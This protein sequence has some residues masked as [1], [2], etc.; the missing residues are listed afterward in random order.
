MVI[1]VCHSEK[2]YAFRVKRVL[3]RGRP[4]VCDARKE[5]VPFLMLLRGNSAAAGEGLV[6]QFKSGHAAHGEFTPIGEAPAAAFAADLIREEVHHAF[7]NSVILW[8]GDT[9]FALVRKAQQPRLVNR[10]QDEFMSSRVNAR[11]RWM[12]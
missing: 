3:T 1:N 9:K 11:R 7:L 2:V 4:R 5:N 6:Q 12:P 8:L 10:G